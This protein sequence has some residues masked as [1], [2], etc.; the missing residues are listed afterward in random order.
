MGRDKN[1]IGIRGLKELVCTTHGYELRVV[2]ECW[3]VG[4]VGNVEGYKGGN[5]ENCNSII[6]K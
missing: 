2:G 1:G 4:E 5:W 6:N 3:R